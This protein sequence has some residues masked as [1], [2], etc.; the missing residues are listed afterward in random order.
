M[1]SLHAGNLPITVGAAFIGAIAEK[2]QSSDIAL[3]CRDS[4]REQTMGLHV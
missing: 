4:R 2:G 3:N 1:R